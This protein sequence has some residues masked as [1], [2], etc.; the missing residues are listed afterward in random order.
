M[1]DFDDQRIVK[2][3]KDFPAYPYKDELET[4]LKLLKLDL[5]PFKSNVLYGYM[6]LSGKV[7]I[8]AEYEQ[9]GFFHEGLAFAVKN[10]KYG[11]I[12]K[13]NRVVVPF[14][15]ESVTDFEQGRSIVEINDK[16][17][18]VDRSG[19]V[20]FP[21]EFDEIGI[22][23][24]GLV[25]VSKND[26]YAYYD[27][28]F[29]LRIPF[30][31]NEAYNFQN[32]KAKVQVDGK[33][34]V[35]DIY[36]TFLV[37]PA[38][39]DINFFNDSLLVFEENEYY[40]IMRKNTEIVSPANFDEIG[41]L[42]LNRALAVFEDLIGYLD[43]TGKMVIKAQYETY[44]NYVKRGQFKSNLAVVKQKGKY[45]VIDRNGKVIIPLA[46]NDLGEISS[47]MAFSKGKGW[48]FIDQ[49]GKVIIQPEFDF[50]ESFVNE[51]A[52]VEKL[53]LQGVIDNKG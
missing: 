22:L 25:Y 37:P 40:G 18:V 47:L 33:Q 13:G 43:G 41:V 44:P 50:A 12:D 46:F 28:N 20:V 32:G 30:R 2:F 11:F 16:L 19:A 7:V 27:K 35:I 21:V 49:T 15:Y 39:E 10:E 9:L 29:N 42:N 5:L 45:G 1:L 38:Y 52:I 4:D 53:T 14:E 3:K 51:T 34:G 36:G 6:D 48:G 24:E 17:G 8:P 31:F 26:M 23:S